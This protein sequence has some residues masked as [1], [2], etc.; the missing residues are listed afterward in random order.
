MALRT[1][2]TDDMLHT[3]TAHGTPDFPFVAYHN[4]LAQYAD[5]RLEWHWHGEM[6]FCLILSG[7]IT[8][9]CGGERIELQAGDAIFINGGIMHRFE[10]G[11]N[12][13]VVNFV[14]SP[15]FIAPRGSRIYARDVQTCLN[16]GRSYFIL[17]RENGRCTDMLRLLERLRECAFSQ[18]LMRDLRTR[19]LVSELWELLAPRLVAT[20]EDEPR[21][22]EPESIRL[23]V[24]AEFIAAHFSERISLADIAS[25][26]SISQSEA[27]RCFHVGLQTTPVRYLNEYRLSR[28]KER[29]MSTSDSVTAV[30]A[31]SGFESAGYFCRVFKAGVG[32]TPAEYR[33]RSRP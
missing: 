18:L 5:S 13:T 31:A 32:C 6:E 16:G 25:S 30:A 26:A 33:R 7:R 9:R 3:T 27:L 11:D 28:A 10:A 24:M 1:I 15:E 22:G 19:N 12:G 17:R 2:P 21:Q 20:E 4:E 8:C 29:L 23:L 14:F